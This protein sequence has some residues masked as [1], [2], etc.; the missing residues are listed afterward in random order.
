[1]AMRVSGGWRLT[2]CCCLWILLGL[3]TLTPSAIAGRNVFNQPP[4]AVERYFGRYLTRS[5]NPYGQGKN[6]VTYTYSSNRLRRLFPNYRQRKFSITFVDG[7]ASRI[8]LD[9]G[10]LPDGSLG[11]IPGQENQGR[12]LTAKFFRY[13]FEQ[14]PVWRLLEQSP[15]GDSLQYVRYCVG[16]GVATSLISGQL[17]LLNLYMEPSCNNVHSR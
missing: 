5:T 10:S 11:V 6:V 13:I 16:K 15:Q 2:V 14:P 3:G 8:D 4:K 1:M 9:L 7:K 12:E 17:Y